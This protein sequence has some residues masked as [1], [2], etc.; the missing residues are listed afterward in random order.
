MKVGTAPFQRLTLSPWN[1][2][3]ARIPGET[4][5]CHLENVRGRLWPVIKWRQGD[6]Y[7]NWPAVSSAAAAALSE[8]V[9]AAK[10]YAGGSGGGAF[11][12]NEFGQVIVPAS[13]VDYRRFLAGLL[14]G[15]LHF[16]NPLVPEQPIDLAGDDYLQ[17]GDPWK[18]PYVGMPFVFNEGT[19]Y[20]KQ[21]DGN[22]RHRLYPPRQ[23][24]DLIRELRHLRP[25][26]GR[27]VVTHA[28][29]VLTKVSS[30]YP[31]DDDEASY[32]PVYVGSIDP[33]RWFH[34]E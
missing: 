17:T 12:I 7:A 30:G 34:M 16:E 10:Q 21:H 8:A 20:F 18:L 14:L 19:I 3:Y 15:P 31:R 23:D 6:D 27:I 13:D 11:Q 2:R 22:G 5:V 29:A 28:G 4:S 24:E 25:R 9:A 32:Q 1:G 33:N 26:G